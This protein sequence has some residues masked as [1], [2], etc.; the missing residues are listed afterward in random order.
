VGTM[1][2]TKI[3]YGEKYTRGMQILDYIKEMKFENVRVDSLYG[4]PFYYV[5][6][7]KNVCKLHGCISVSIKIESI[8]FKDDTLTLITK[9]DIIQFHNVK[10]MDEVALNGNKKVKVK[11]ELDLLVFVDKSF[12]N[13]VISIELP[14]EKNNRFIAVYDSIV[15]VREITNVEKQHESLVIFSRT[16]NDI[17]ITPF[18]EEEVED[19]GMFNSYSVFYTIEDDS[20]IDTFYNKI[21]EFL[22]NKEQILKIGDY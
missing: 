1:E 3:V 22:G 6:N 8:I 14:D 20:L 9:G 7:I 10:L 11:I 4:A 12:E 21:I 18:K 19:T 5:N 15:N 13:H 17:V 16:V 2:T